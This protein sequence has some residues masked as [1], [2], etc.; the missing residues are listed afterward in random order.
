MIVV[1]THYEPTDRM[2]GV[3]LY[4]VVSGVVEF[5]CESEIE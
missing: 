2:R 1:G 3:I 4:Q 5:S